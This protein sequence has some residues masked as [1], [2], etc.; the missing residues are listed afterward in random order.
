MNPDQ[1][2][3]IAQDSI[4]W[5][6]TTMPDETLG[7]RD[8][9]FK[10]KSVGTWRDRTRQLAKILGYKRKVDFPGP[11]PCA[12]S[13][14]GNASRVA[15]ST[16]SHFLTAMA[17]HY[18]C[19]DKATSCVPAASPTPTP[20]EIASHR[21]NITALFA[22]IAVSKDD[23]LSANS[24]TLDAPPQQNT[25][26]S[27][28]YPTA[29]CQLYR[30]SASS[31]PKNA[32]RFFSHSPGRRPSST[33]HSP[34][35]R[36]SATAHSPGGRTSSTYGGDMVSASSPSATPRTKNSP[37]APKASDN[38]VLIPQTG[39][40][41][42]KRRSSPCR[43]P[44]S[45]RPSRSTTPGARQPPYSRPQP[46]THRIL[47]PYGIRAP[48]APAMA[49]R[50]M[51]CMR[52]GYSAEDMEDR[53]EYLAEVNQKDIPQRGVGLAPWLHAQWAHHRQQ[54]LPFRLNRVR[55]LH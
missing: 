35:G 27:S 29:I 26:M 36:V 30:T 3:W 53:M 46:P 10:G 12:P 33:S 28:P 37:V 15:P 4:S 19:V 8:R 55:Y 5:F 7:R 52:E 24:D 50:G 47:M 18:I 22:S 2:D 21:A 17:P 38:G 34:S 39:R 16:V 54:F 51:K 14:P 1:N 13:L 9:A 40:H 23:A 11:P 31:T 20:I 6:C 25:K 48:T 44:K 45:V 32:S 41:N 43:T 42:R 49:S